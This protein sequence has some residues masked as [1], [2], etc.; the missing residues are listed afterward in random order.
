MG[1]LATAVPLGN[2]RDLEAFVG[3]AISKDP[4]L[5]WLRGNEPDELEADGF[6][7]MYQLYARY[8]RERAGAWS[9]SSYAGRYLPGRIRDAWRARHRGEQ[10]RHEGRE[11]EHQVIASLDAERT[12]PGFTERGLR[13]LT[14]FAPA[15]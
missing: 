7:I 15:A 10:I 3:A 5:R 2:V 14:E 12:R 1:C 8:S 9:F 13:T 4:Q 11:W 6:L